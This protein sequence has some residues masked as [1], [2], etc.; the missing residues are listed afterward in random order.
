MKVDV[1]SYEVQCVSS[2][3]LSLEE[4]CAAVSFLVRRPERLA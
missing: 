4:S 3:L 2:A 1:L